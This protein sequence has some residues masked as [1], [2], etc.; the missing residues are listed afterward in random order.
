MAVGLEAGYTS[1]V[2]Y[3]CV[4]IGSYHVGQSGRLMVKLVVRL[5]VKSTN[6]I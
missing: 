5:M 2:L 4:A 3:Y 1:R 6:D